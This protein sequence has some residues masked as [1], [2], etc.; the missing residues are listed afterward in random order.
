M[1]GT[2]AAGRVLLL[3]IGLATFLG[4]AAV[5]IACDVAIGEERAHRHEHTQEVCPAEHTKKRVAST[6]AF[7]SHS[8]SD[9]IKHSPKE[10]MLEIK[11]A[12]MEVSLFS[13][14]A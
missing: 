5:G 12:S 9:P 8:L 3:S 11:N 4:L 13:L 6:L 7:A 14:N 1:R 2:M 10:I